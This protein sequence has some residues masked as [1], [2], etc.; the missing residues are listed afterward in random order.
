MKKFMYVFLGVASALMLIIIL[1]FQVILSKL[2][3]DP[4]NYLVQIICML[5]PLSVTFYFFYISLMQ[6]E[7]DEKDRRKNNDKEQLIYNEILERLEKQNIQQEK[8]AEYMEKTAIELRR[9]R[10]PEGIVFIYKNYR[11]LKEYVNLSDGVQNT[12]NIVARITALENIYKE[13]NEIDD[14]EVPLALL[15]SFSNARYFLEQYIA[16]LHLSWNILID[17]EKEKKIS[18]Q[19][20]ISSTLDLINQYRY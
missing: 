8:I 17:D 9:T 10:R 18:Q 13:W 7:T 16:L 20:M 4:G 15:D 3:D 11:L 19:M 14:E 12:L 6:R 1:N 5:I 2:N